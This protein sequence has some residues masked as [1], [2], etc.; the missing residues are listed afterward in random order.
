MQ[1][2]K[3]SVVENVLSH[4]ADVT[5]LF[6]D[7]NA[8]DAIQ[9][10]FYY[11]VHVLKRLALSCDSQIPNFLIIHSLQCAGSDIFFSVAFCTCTTATFQLSAAGNNRAVHEA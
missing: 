4:A 3:L 1:H 10:L 7:R 5:L 6:D 9:L 8:T 11:C 2:I